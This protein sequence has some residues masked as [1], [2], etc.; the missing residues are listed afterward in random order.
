AMDNY[1]AA[2]MQ[3]LDGL[4]AVRKRPGMY[5]GSNGSAGLTHLVYEIAD[6]AV[7][8]ALAGFATQVT[9]AFMPDDSVIFTDNGRGIPTAV[10]K[11]LGLTGV[12]IAYTTLHGGG[13]FGGGG[14]A[15][16]AGRLHGVGAAVVKAL[17]GRLDVRVCRFDRH[18]DITYL[19]G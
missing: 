5:I 13:K 6:N 18:H 14:Y 19:R 3:V 1:S 7:D 17:S 4:E 8:E 15:K 9:V 11:K 12:E 10:N 16:G 2:D